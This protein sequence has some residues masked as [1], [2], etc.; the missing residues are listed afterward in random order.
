MR[1]VLDVEVATRQNRRLK[2]SAV[3]IT[4]RMGTVKTNPRLVTSGSI[5]SS[6]IN[7]MR[8]MVAVVRTIE[9]L[10]EGHR[11]QLT[12]APGLKTQRRKETM[13]KWPIAPLLALMKVMMR[14]YTSQEP[15]SKWQQ[16][17]RHSSLLPKHL[18]L[19]ESSTTSEIDFLRRQNELTNLTNAS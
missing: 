14:M 7:L 3:A 17:L 1:V 4:A 5:S 6:P 13:G 11:E 12:N 15:R 18:R 10:E 19:S 16:S 8:M 2:T 9:K